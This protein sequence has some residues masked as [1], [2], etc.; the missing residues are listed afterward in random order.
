MMQIDCGNVT[1]ILGKCIAFIYSLTEPRLLCFT[2][3][4][5]IVVTNYIFTFSKE[6]MNGTA[7]CLNGVGGCQVVPKW[8]LKCSIYF[9][10]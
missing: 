8:L 10:A 3:L 4:F 7:Q 5:F 9:L 2:Y 1:K 6:N